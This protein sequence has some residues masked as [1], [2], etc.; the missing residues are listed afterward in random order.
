M[1]LFSVAVG[2]AIGAS[3]PLFFKKVWTFAKAKFAEWQA[4]N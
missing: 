4:K 3:F 2:I 1:D